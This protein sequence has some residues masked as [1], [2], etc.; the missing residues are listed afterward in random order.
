VIR[1]SE[2]EW[3]HAKASANVEKHDVAFSDAAKVFL[4][5]E[6]I[7]QISPDG[8]SPESRWKTVGNSG[9]LLIAVI[10]TIR[11][12][13]V[14]IITARRASRRERREYSSSTSL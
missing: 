9:E 10:F 6:R 4:D 7:E 3:D 5:S 14:R 13:N 11:G 1:F 2:V 12:E 8:R